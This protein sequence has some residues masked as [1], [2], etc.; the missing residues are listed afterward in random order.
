MVTSVKIEP[1]SRPD[2]LK[3]PAVSDIETK[4]RERAARK[5]APRPEIEV[6]DEA[7]RRALADDAVR[8]APDVRADKVHRAK[9]RLQNDALNIDSMK[10]AERLIDDL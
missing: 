3:H 9:M 7:R 1:G 6:S 8:N 10:I 4:R 2:A 5:P